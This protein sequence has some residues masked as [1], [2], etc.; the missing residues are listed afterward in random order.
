MNRLQVGY[1]HVLNPFGG[2]VYRVSLEPDQVIAL[3]FWTRNPAPM[4][5]HLDRLDALGYAYF[6]NQTVTNYPTGFESH[7]PSLQASI[8]AFQ[9]LAT[10]L[11]PW[12]VQWRYDPII[13]SSATPPAWHL[14]QAETIARAL[15]GFTDHCTF[16]FV[17]YYGKTRRN[18]G[19]VSRQ[20]GVQFYNPSLEEQRELAGKL[21][22]TISRYG[23]SLF[24]CCNDLLIGERVQKNHCIDIDIVRRLSPNLETYPAPKPTRKDCGCLASVDIGVYDTCLFGCTYC[25]ATNNRQAALKRKA[26]HDPSDSLLWRPPDLTG[27]DLEEIAVP[28]KH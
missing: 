23:I 5:R 13:L 19:L 15:Q 16:S 8:T 12:R 26:S 1:C 7:N 28:L 25:Y 6:F 18:L 11:S 20:L 22:Q 4:F 14:E 10:R 17:D 9:R 24:T 27:R 2:Q 21:A 3:A